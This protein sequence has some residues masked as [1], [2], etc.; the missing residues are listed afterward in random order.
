MSLTPSPILES[1]TP[2]GLPLQPGRVVTIMTAPNP[3]L[4]STW[5]SPPT[6]PPPAS[7]FSVTRMG[8][9]T[10]SWA[11]PHP[12]PTPTP[13]TVVTT[14]HHPPAIQ[15]SPTT[16]HTPA[17]AH[18]DNQTLTM[19]RGKATALGLMCTPLERTTAPLMGRMVAATAME[20][21][22]MGVYGVP[23]CLLVGRRAA[24]PHIVTPPEAAPD[25]P[26]TTSSG[27]LCST[28]PCTN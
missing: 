5:R 13:V 10:W 3:P 25:P 12:I 8:S 11:V 23:C 1:L 4:T 17:Q 26:A 27:Y 16:R 14:Q 22:A 28:C 2:P 6:S 21:V 20:V 15:H 7:P 9:P 18:M 19:A 24:C